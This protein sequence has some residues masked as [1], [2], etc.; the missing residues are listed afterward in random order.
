M[1]RRPLVDEEVQALL[2]LYAVGA[3]S[4]SYE[5]GIAHVTRGLLQSAGFLYVTEL[6]SGVAR[7]DGTVAMTRVRDCR[8][9]RLP[10]HLGATG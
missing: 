6:G 4:A 8:L 10:G 1:Y 2:S 3:D 7:A 5:D 9:A